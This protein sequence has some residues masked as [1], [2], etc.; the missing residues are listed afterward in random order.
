M[1]AIL[2]HNT[3]LLRKKRLVICEASIYVAHALVK[4]IQNGEGCLLPKETHSSTVP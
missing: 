2:G 3:H 1:N 4:V